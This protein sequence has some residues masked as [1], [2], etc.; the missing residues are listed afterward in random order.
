MIQLLKSLFD[1]LLSAP[2]PALLKRQ[3]AYAR[4]QRWL[5]YLAQPGK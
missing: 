2:N 1:Y 3:E 5:D 4:Q